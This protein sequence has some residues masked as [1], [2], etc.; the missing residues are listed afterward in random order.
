MFE[1]I[2]QI[3][4][5]GC[6]AKRNPDGVHY[7]KT[8]MKPIAPILLFAT[9]S[10]MNGC[11]AMP[12][13]KAPDTLNSAPQT[14]Y[15]ALLGVGPAEFRVHGRCAAC[16][17]CAACRVGAC[18][19]DICSVGRDCCDADAHTHSIHHCKPEE[20]HHGHHHSAWDVACR[21]EGLVA[22]IPVRPTAAV[23]HPVHRRPIFF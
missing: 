8:M 4:Q 12:S 3:Q 20:E 11:T 1:K 6:P 17:A 7:V 22:I 16:C 21:R 13:S 19:R 15:D 23:G 5:F 18:T 9:L 2:K 14:Q 10:V